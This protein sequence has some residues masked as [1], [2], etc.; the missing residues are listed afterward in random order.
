MEI[1]E[2][3]NEYNLSDLVTLVRILRDP[4][5]GCP[6]DREQ[7]HESIRQNFIEET[8]EAL[9]AI[10][11]ADKSLLEEELGDVLLQVMLHAEIERQIGG[12]DIDGVSDRICKKL[13]LRHPHIFGGVNVSESREVLSNWE[14]IKRDEKDQKTGS[15]AIDDV[16]AALP[17]L[18]K[19]Q[20]VQKRAAYVGFDYD[21]VGG[22]LDD[23]DS[24]LCELKAA[25]AENTNVEEE[26]GDLIFAAVNVARFVKADAELC[27]ERA[28]EKFAQR[29]RVVEEM[30]R[31][32]GIDIK[33]AG[34]DKLNKLW[35]K[36]KQ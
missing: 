16:P 7:T 23:L 34:M 6:W 14:D 3:K 10:D 20:K 36:A 2:I 33:T 32:Q 1:F 29:F 22:A 26:L 31:Q 28:C 25:I 15:D 18:M 24:E 35:E 17:A 30:A 8:Y 27:A 11:R 19:S 13:V 21:S 5:D 12:F 9:E 4:V